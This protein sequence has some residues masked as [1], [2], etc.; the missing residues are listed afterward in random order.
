MAA[1]SA[2][3]LA[4]LDSGDTIALSEGL[5]GR[6]VGLVT[7]ELARFGV[8][9]VLFDATRPETLRATS[10]GP[11]RGWRLSRQSRIR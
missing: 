1:E 11:G 2:L 6:T 8:G 10:C 7:K 5:Y 9:C 4:S 3:F